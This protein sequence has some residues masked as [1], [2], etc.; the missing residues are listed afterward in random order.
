MT[1]PAGKKR[2]TVGARALGI[3][4]SQL[5]NGLTKADIRLDRKQLS[6][7]AINQPA[8]FADIVAKAKAALAA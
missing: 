1:S 8:A 6:E 3:N 7:L 2:I 5:I 4:Y